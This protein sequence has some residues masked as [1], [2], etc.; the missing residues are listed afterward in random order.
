VAQNA[1][2]LGM[3]GKVLLRT[4]IHS[5]INLTNH[6]AAW[7]NGPVDEEKDGL[8]CWQVESLANNVEELA[9]IE[10]TR[11]KILLF[12]DVVQG[13]TLLA[14]LQNHRDPIG[15]LL[16]DSLRPWDRLGLGSGAG[17]GHKLMGVG[18]S[19][20]LDVALLLVCPLS[21][22][23]Y[24]NTLSN[25]SLDSRSSGLD[26]RGMLHTFGTETFKG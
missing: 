23:W 1:L 16:Q 18:G 10:V 12:V 3:M 5:T 25:A 21:M 9:D 7:R 20:T 14:F 11:D 4:S 8:L 6:F 19:R 2:A 15:K 22:T 13:H 17:P 24:S 26:R